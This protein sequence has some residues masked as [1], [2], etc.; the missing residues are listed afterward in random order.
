MARPYYLSSDLIAAVKRKISFPVSQQTFTEDDIL[1]FANEEMMI[2]QVPS[3]LQWHEE[4]FVFRINVALKS[5]VTRYPIPT[6]AIGMKFRDIKY[7]DTSGS[8]YEMT[9][10]SPDDK[11]FHQQT[12]NTVETPYNFYLEGN[13]VVLASSTSGHLAFFIYMRPN[14]LVMEDR[15]FIVSSI[16]QTLTISNNS[17]IVAN[18]S[19]I[20]INEVIFTPVSSSPTG[21][22]FL[23]DVSATAT[24]TNLATAINNNTNLNYYIT[25]SAAAGVVTLTSTVSFLDISLNNTNCYTLPSTTQLVSVDTVPDHIL[26]GSIVDLLQTEPGHRTIAIDVR[27]PT[28]GVSASSIFLT[29]TDIPKTF[30]VG[31]YICERNECIVPQIPPDLHNGLAERTCSRI[32]TSMG[33][34]VGLQSTDKKI[35]EIDNAQATLLDNRAESTP[36]KITGRK[37]ILRYQRTGPR[38]RF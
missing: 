27:I 18:S 32:L 31:D 17:N 25:A 13:D 6:R 5:G 29:T 22:Q 4:Y 12:N 11:A 10:V 3:I 35:S 19:T 38:R 9:R 1:A 7:V 2:S 15:A 8:L 33:D 24:A 36:Q 14:Q 26:A 37:S 30:I 20:T 28:S 34:Q 21:N 23:I 16:K